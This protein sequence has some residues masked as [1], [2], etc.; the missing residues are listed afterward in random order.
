MAQDANTIADGMVKA[1]LDAV[2]D[3]FKIEL[4][5]MLILIVLLSDFNGIF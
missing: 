3:V 2:E 5:E 1:K 4:F